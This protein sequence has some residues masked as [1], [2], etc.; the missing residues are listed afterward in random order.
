MVKIAGDNAIVE[1]ATQIMTEHRWP[2]RRLGQAIC[3]PP[4]SVWAIDRL[5]NPHAA[6]RHP[7]SQDRA[8][9]AAQSGGSLV[10]LV[11]AHAGKDAQGPELRHR[12]GS[13]IC[14]YTNFTN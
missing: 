8:A 1:N 4:T 5:S 7:Q 12:P 10:V 2:A 11:V 3:V 6:I 13:G 9:A 14:F